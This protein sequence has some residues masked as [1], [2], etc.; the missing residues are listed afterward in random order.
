M[1]SRNA[2]ERLEHFS[3]CGSVARAAHVVRTLKDAARGSTVPDAFELLLAQ[4][5]DDHDVY[6]L[7]ASVAAN[8]DRRVEAAHDLVRALLVSP[9]MTYARRLASRVT[10]H[11]AGLRGLA[12]WVGLALC[13]VSARLDRKPCAERAFLLKASGGKDAETAVYVSLARLERRSGSVLEVLALEEVL[14]RAPRWT[15]G[16][17][18]LLQAFSK[19]GDRESVSRVLQEITP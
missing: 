16:R 2:L 3:R 14:R 6:A 18:R 7:R 4:R 17:L 9:R 5:P 8:A 11:V 1:S 13:A 15:E 10:E 12:P 19:A